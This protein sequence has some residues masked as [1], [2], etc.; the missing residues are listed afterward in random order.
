[1][2][3]LDHIACDKANTA[4]PSFRRVIQ[5][6]VDIKLVILS[7][8]LVQF[9][10]EKDIVGVDVSEDE[11][12]LSSVVA[13][14]SGSAADDSLDNLQH[15][16]DTSATGDHADMA[17]HVRGVDHG[18]LGTAD[19]HGLTDIQ[20]VQVFGNVTLCVGLDKEVKVAGFIVGRDGGVGADDGVGVAGNLGLKGDVL[21]DGETK[22]VGRPWK[23]KAVNSDVVGDEVLL[24]EDEV[25]ELLGVKDLSGTCVGRALGEPIAFPMDKG[26]N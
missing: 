24:L 7:G 9:L 11:I 15:W 20:V 2:T 25:L 19:L 21:T 3:H 1:L 8:Q 16:R 6:V 18:A 4:L 26:I 5:N 13:A 17:S 14:V 10:F 23:G 12:D 22:D